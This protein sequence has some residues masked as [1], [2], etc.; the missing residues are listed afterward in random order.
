MAINTVTRYNTI[1]NMFKKTNNVKLQNI[2]VMCK[3]KVK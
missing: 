3:I 1:P 2:S